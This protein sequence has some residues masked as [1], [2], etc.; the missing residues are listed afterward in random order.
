MHVSHK[1][2]TYSRGLLL[3]LADVPAPGRIGE[4]DRFKPQNFA[5]RKAGKRARS[6]L[7]PL[8]IG[9]VKKRDDRNDYRQNYQRNDGQ[10][11]Y[12]DTAHVSQL[13]A[14][15][16]IVLVL[17]AAEKEPRSRS[18]DRDAF[19]LGQGRTHFTATLAST[20]IIDGDRRYR[21]IPGYQR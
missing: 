12:R 7:Q 18:H 19:A 16:S 3:E 9:E 14:F 5:A 6:R 15:A 1:A 21:A 13:S 8:A 2:E 20:T 17:F 11:Y 10:S 4:P